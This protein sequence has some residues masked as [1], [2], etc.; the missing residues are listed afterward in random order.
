[1]DVIQGHE[2]HRRWNGVLYLQSAKQRVR[3]L[4]VSPW[5]LNI[6]S[7]VLRV[8]NERSLLDLRRP[9]QAL[10]LSTMPGAFLIAAL[11]ASASDGADR[12][13][14]AA[15]GFYPLW[16]DTGSTLEH[17]QMLL[18]TDYF[19]LGLGGDAQVGLRPQEFL[20]RTPN[21]HGKV[22]LF[23]RGPF[24]LSVHAETLALLSGATSI[25][26]SSNF[27]SRIDN[28]RGTLWVIPVG[29]TLSWFP[30]DFAAI[31]T[32]LTMISVGGRGQPY[33]ASLGLSSVIELRALK[34]HGLLFHLAEI[35]F[36]RQDMFVIGASYRLN[37]GWC[38]TQIGYFYRFSPDGSQASPL[39][40]VGVTL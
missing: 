2:R 4:I 1:V 24:E 6:L 14:F 3:T 5:H 7:E 36:W 38:G 21:L 9:R 16:E 25:F 27:V 10:Y 20:F 29:S 30:A 40:S 31:H 18:G 15:T 37:L 35:G 12:S 13:A 23:V 28:S 32:T 22:R 39:L 11:L 8:C 33:Y 26:T 34:H 17:R 19:E